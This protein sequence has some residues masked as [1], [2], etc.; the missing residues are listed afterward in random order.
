M[1]N[2]NKQVESNADGIVPSSTHRAQ[3]FLMGEAKLV[4]CRVSEKSM[5]LVK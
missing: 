4:V 3:V 2:L 1:V 5:Q